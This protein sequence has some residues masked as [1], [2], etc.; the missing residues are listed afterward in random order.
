VFGTAEGGAS[1][2]FEVYGNKYYP[3]ADAA[4]NWSIK[5]PKENLPTGERTLDMTLTATD[6]AGNVATRTGELKIDTIV[7]TLSVT[8]DSSGSDNWVNASEMANGLVLGGKVEAG[9]QS[10]TIKHNTVSYNATV[11]AAGNW[12]AT[13]PSS[14]V[15]QGSF[16]YTVQAVDGAGNTPYLNASVM[17][18]PQ[19]PES[20]PRSAEPHH[21]AQPD[22]RCGQQS[23]RHHNRRR[24]ASGRRN[25]AN[26]PVG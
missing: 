12:T 4:G 25:F 3:T 14:A 7:N 23:V 22:A 17:I 9:S 15:G 18:D 8:S 21:F 2:V 6:K 26:H 20:I 13:V 24:C 1:I 5:I 19:A 11:D 10:V 16:A